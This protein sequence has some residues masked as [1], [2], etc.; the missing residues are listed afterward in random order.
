[1]A[2][3]SRSYLLWFAAFITICV[4]ELDPAHSHCFQW[5]SP[6]SKTPSTHIWPCITNRLQHP[7]YGD[8]RSHCSLVTRES[9]AHICHD[10]VIDLVN[11]LSLWLQ[12]AVSITMNVLKK[13]HTY[14]FILWH[15][16]DQ[17]RA[18]PHEYE[19]FLFQIWS[20]AILRDYHIHSRF[21][22]RI[23]SGCRKPCLESEFEICSVW[24]DDH[25]LLHWW[26]RQKGNEGIESLNCTNDVCGKLINGKFA[27]I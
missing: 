11:L 1:M 25:C 15:C 16:P 4:P 7:L 14:V 26:G 18:D 13:W 6:L 24:C 8:R 2:S 20:D 17:S 10:L 3:A 23:R 5:L 9:L 19:A 27:V 22:N 21:W 12:M